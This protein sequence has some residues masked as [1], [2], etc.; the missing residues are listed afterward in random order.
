MHSPQNYAK[1]FWIAAGVS[2]A[3]AN[4]GLIVFAN[5]TGS[6]AE[7]EMRPQVESAEMESLPDVSGQDLPAN[8]DK[9]SP[10]P[11]RDNRSSANPVDERLQQFVLSN[12][13]RSSEY[14]PMAVGTLPR[15]WSTK[16]YLRSFGSE[17]Q[18]QMLITG[19]GVFLVLKDVEETTLFSHAN[20]FKGSR[21]DMSE[22]AEKFN[23]GMEERGYERVSSRTP[24]S[25]NSRDSI[26]MAYTRSRTNQQSSPLVIH[27]WLRHF[28]DGPNEKIVGLAYSRYLPVERSSYPN[29]EQDIEHIKESLVAS[30]SE[31]SKR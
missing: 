15:G 11:D 10:S 26:E 30:E 16:S 7:P 20:V 4:G 13:N 27:Y 21:S 14:N 23:D 28:E 24:R 9:P 5:V 19:G 6:D 25:L 3:L 18:P 1:M 22:W 8:R 31:R 29:W 12:F 2:A 17:P